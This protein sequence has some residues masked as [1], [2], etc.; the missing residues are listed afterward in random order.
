MSIQTILNKIAAITDGGNNSASEVRAVLTDITTTLSGATIP[1]TNTSDLANDGDDGINP[2]ITSGDTI[3][4]LGDRGQIIPIDVGGET[5]Y[6]LRDVNRALNHIAIGPDTMDLTK[7][8][9]LAQVGLGGQSGFAFGYDLFAAA[10]HYGPTM[11]GFNNRILGGNYGTI[12]GQDNVMNSGFSC[13]VTGVNNVISSALGY[14]FTTGRNNLEAGRY[15][16]TLGV[17]LINRGYGTVIGTAN[18]DNKGTTSS[19]SSNNPLLIVGNGSLTSDAS[20]TALVRSDAFLVYQN[21]RVIAPSL[22]PALIDTN[23]KSLVTKEYGDANYGGALVFSPTGNTSGI[24]KSGRNEVNYGPVGTNAVDLS[25]SPTPSTTLGATGLLATAFGK[26]TTASGYYSTA[27]NYKTTASA[28]YSTASG[29]YTT[30]S[31]TAST[32]W[33]RSNTASSNYATAFGRFSTA[34]ARYSTAFGRGVFPTGDGATAFGQNT[35]SSGAYSTTWGLNTTA[36]GAYSTAFGRENISPSYLETVFGAYSTTGNTGNSTTWVGSDR[37]FNIGNGTSSN[38]GA[39][40]NRSNALTILKYGDVVAPSMTNALIASANTRVLIT[41][42]YGDAN[43]AGG[44]ALVFSPTG[45]TSGIIKSGRIEVNYGPVGANANDLSFS[46][47]ASSTRGATGQY[48]MTWGLNTTANSRYSTAFGQNTNASEDW[49]TAWGIGTTASGYYSTAWGQNTIASGNTFNATAFG[50]NATASGSESTAWGL[51]STAS[52]SRSTANGINSTASGYASTAFGSSTVASGNRS[53][54]WGL[55]TTASG[56][57]ATAWGSGTTA[58]GILGTAF[59]GLTTASGINST[60]WGSKG[61]ASAQYSTAFG[62]LTTANG[63]N[64]TAFGSNTFAT[65]QFSTTWG[66]NTTASG[67]LSTA[68]GRENIAKSYGE[69]SLGL[70]STTG[71]TG[72]PTTWVGSDRVFNIG[73]GTSFSGRSNALTILKYGDVL[74]P[75]MT[76]AI[77]N[78][79]DT[80]VLITKEYAD[81]TYAGG[82]VT[83]VGALPAGVVGDR[84]FVTDSTVAASGNFGAIVTGGNTNAVPV[85]YNGTNWL[86]G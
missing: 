73:N 33:G 3:Q 72:N 57:T 29:A 68:F 13:F 50:R 41:K 46:N 31:G 45:N 23:V 84:A 25:F 54:A 58:N 16:A 8:F 85:F 51:G 64:S 81:V 27:S 18:L 2:F 42:E 36:S 40:V 77:I 32:A 43:Y 65:G 14:T 21:G 44:G 15:S 38:Y 82:V 24:I 47:S 53:T 63:I 5:S 22:T 69:T 7:R 49:S 1:I 80:K 52:G 20:N 12:F 66:L 48:A 4:L 26:E 61:V 35:R 19:T 79:A 6:G 71:N 86:I 28:F 55:N 78:S 56:A 76:N 70:F 39:I 17:G 67:E 9:S 83:T 11:F 62:N 37:L 75:S 30:A 60:A 74:A 10:G 34:S 59:G